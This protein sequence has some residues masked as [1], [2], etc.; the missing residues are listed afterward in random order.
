M[1]LHKF[2]LWLPAMRSLSQLH[3]KIRTMG[4][5]VLSHG[6]S[7]TKIEIRTSRNYRHKYSSWTSICHHALKRRV[8]AAFWDVVVST[9]GSHL[10]PESAD[11]LK[12][13][14][15]KHF[16]AAYDWDAVGRNS[17]ERLAFKSGG[18][19]YYLGGC[20]MFRTLTIC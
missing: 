20:L 19:V 12:S 10:T 1:A 13:F 17:I 16:I 18:W 4:E 8:G 11:L 7:G 14:D 2:R 15:I 5:V 3:I 6:K 9:L